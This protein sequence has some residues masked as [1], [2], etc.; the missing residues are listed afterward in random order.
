M[1]I[2]FLIILS[3]CFPFLT[4]GQKTFAVKGMIINSSV[5]VKVFLMYRNGQA[6]DSTLL[7]NGSFSFKGKIINPFKTSIYTQELNPK[8]QYPKREYLEL[9]IEE[10]LTE[11]TAFKTL[12]NAVIKGGR[13]QHEFN[14]LQDSLSWIRQTYDHLSS[15]IKTKEIDDTTKRRLRSSYKSFYGPIDSIENR[16][17]ATH[18]S[19]IVSWDIVANRGIIIHPDE[20][21]PVFNMLSEDLKRKPAAIDLKERIE[22]AKK[23]RI[24]NNAIDFTSITPEG[25]EVSL[26]SF[27]G[28]YVLVDFWASWCGP[29]RAENP[30]M[31]KAYNNLKSDNFEIFGV[32]LDDDRIPWLKAVTED[33]LPWIQVSDLKGFSTVAK[34]YG[35][36]AIPQNLLIDPQGKIIGINLRGETLNAE[37]KKRMVQ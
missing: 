14:E 19:S 21:E 11:I 3:Q 37:V 7:I 4:V 1:R 33:K 9:Y 27:K 16:F 36:R 30:Y 32:S 17:I 18:P 25:K 28:K 2:L 31:I 23:L 20:L 24:G 15:L 6:P 26:S 8:E 22:T 35:I 5:P 10:G 13:L 12:K 34:T 29:C